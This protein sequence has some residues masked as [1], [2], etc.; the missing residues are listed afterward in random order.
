[1]TKPINDFR[2]VKVG[3]KVTCFANGCGVIKEINGSSY[4]IICAFKREGEIEVDSYTLHGRLRSCNLEPSLFKGHVEFPD[5]IP[6]K[7]KVK[8]TMYT[9]VYL[10]KEVSECYRLDVYP[11]ETMKEADDIVG[12]NAKHWVATAEVK[13]EAEE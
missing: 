7:I 2:D 9:N 13:F 1:M 8:K 5:P 3:D 12:T 10:N 11:Y 6:V 4:P